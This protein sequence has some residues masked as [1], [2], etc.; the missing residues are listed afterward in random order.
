MVYVLTR[1]IIYLKEFPLLKWNIWN[2]PFE[3]GQGDVSSNLSS[4]FS[5][6]KFLY[7]LCGS[8]FN[9][10]LRTYTE[11]HKVPIAIGITEFHRGLFRQPFRGMFPQIYHTFYSFLNFQELLNPLWLPKGRIWIG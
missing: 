4:I 1:L 6:F 7:Y 11:D 9:N 2:S 8:L 3:G 10:M 5:I